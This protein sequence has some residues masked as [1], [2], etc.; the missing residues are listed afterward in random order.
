M[1]NIKSNNLLRKK[2]KRKTDEPKSDNIDCYLSRGVQYHVDKRTTSILLLGAGGSG[3][4]TLLSQMQKIYT[5]SIPKTTL[6]NTKKYIQQNILRNIY[7]LA[8]QNAI[9]KSSN[10]CYKLNDNAE[11][12]VTNILSLSCHQF[13]NSLLSAQ[14][15]DNMSILCNDTCFQETLKLCQLKKWFFP[16]ENLSYF[17]K[18]VKRILNG[19]NEICF[20]DFIRMRKRTTE[21]VKSTFNIDMDGSSRNSWQFTITDVGGNRTQRKKWLGCFT[22][23]NCIFFVISLVSYDEVIEYGE[24]AYNN[25]IP[26]LFNGYIRQIEESFECQIII[27]YEINNLCLQYYQRKNAL[28]ESFDVFDRVMKNDALRT[29]DVFVILNKYDLFVEKIKNVPF[30]VFDENFDSELMHD[31]NAI[32]NYI[33][34]R[35]K[36][37][38]YQGIKSYKS[39]RRIHFH[40]T[41][42]LDTNQIQTVMHLVQFETIRKCMPVG[43]LL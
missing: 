11:Q 15:A 25:Y 2:K 39:P 26:T 42:A 7:Y 19:T 34:C 10:N 17:M 12:I 41:T 6:E 3:K 27:P 32:K 14:F 43:M 29:V 9:L 24:C 33:R 40:V 13:Q 30:T 1:G 8:K 23:I 38:F 22:D 16:M 35:L 36:K 20:D 4:S 37:S 18:H 28:S 21:I 31:N 5:G